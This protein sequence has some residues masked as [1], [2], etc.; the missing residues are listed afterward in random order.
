MLLLSLIPARFGQRKADRLPYL[1]IEGEV[2]TGLTA[3]QTY[4]VYNGLDA[5]I[6]AQLAPAIRGQ[7]GPNHL[8]TYRREMRVLSLCLEMSSKGYPVEPWSNAELLYALEKDEKR[9]QRLLDLFCEAVDARKI[10]PRSPKDVAWLFYEHLGL[11]TIFEYDRKTKQKKVSTD[12]KALEKL[13]V[14]YPIASPLVNAILAVR[15]SSKMGSVFKRGLEPDTGNLRCHFS[16]TGT[17][18]GRL[19]SQ[20]N[21]YGRGTNAQNL[22]DRVRAVIC[23][24]D[25]YAILNLDL[26][27]AES[28]AVGYLSKCRA[29]IDACLS[30]DVHTAGCRLVFEDV[31]WTGDIEKDKELAE[32]PYYRWFTRRDLM[33]KGGHATNYYGKPLTLQ[34]VA[35]SGQVTV[36]FVERFQEK[37]YGAF[38]E[39]QAWQLETIAAIQTSGIL[40]TPMGRERRFWGRPD[41]TATHREA[42]AF[43]P[44]SLVGDVMNEGLCQVQEWLLKECKDAK[45]FLGRKG[46][47]LPFKP[48]TVD[49]RAQVHDAGV[50]LIPIEALDTLAPIIQTKLQYPVDFGELGQMI[51]PSDMMVGRRWCKAPKKLLEGDKFMSKYMVEGLKSWKPGKP[52][53][54]L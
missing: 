9:A 41:D 17:E 43:R 36:D 42:I 30:G 23:A 19:A 22:T 4:Q 51:I 44:Q 10:N 14:N 8:L 24:P 47:L 38:P 34:K 28:I 37:Y 50:F 32:E 26:K 2:P 15:E 39:I 31:E 11:P 21:P 48:D 53:H 3:F 35:F 54:W 13:R 7:M 5:A 25:G 33:K 20:Q 40:V 46:R 49:L 45:T 1:D 18:T 27:T 16:P 29:Y 12:I 52:L 6:T